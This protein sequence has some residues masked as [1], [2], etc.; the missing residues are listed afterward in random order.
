MTD[1][2]AVGA[3]GPI[4]RDIKIKNLRQECEKRMGVRDFEAAYKYLKDVRFGDLRDKS[5]I[6]ES[7]IMADLRKLVT[8]PS[9]C[10]SVEQ[11]LFLE[12]QARVAK[13]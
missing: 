3:F 1:D 4:A 8:N 12:E 10:F 5:T 2:T 9:E 13:M 11:L 6:D 7:K